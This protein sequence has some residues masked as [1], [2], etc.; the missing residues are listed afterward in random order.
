MPYSPQTVPALH[1][2]EDPYFHHAS[3]PCRS[4]QSVL[5]M[6][7]I[8]ARYD[9]ASIVI[10]SPMFLTMLLQV[11]CNS[12]QPCGNC[13]QA[14]LSCTYDAIPQKKGPKGSR[15]KVI[16]ELRETQKQTDLA[17]MIHEGRTSFG[18]PPTSPAYSRASGLLSQELIEGCTDFFFSHMYPTMPI[19]YREQ[20]RRTV[21]DMGHSA[22]AYCLITAFCA[23]MLIQPGIVLKTGHIMDEAAT[24]ITNPKMGNVLMEESARVRKSYD[25]IEN[26]TIDTIIT[27]FFLFGSC[28]GLNKHNTGW[29]HL[30]EATALA[31]ILGM[32]DE[33]TYIFDNVV[34]MSR[35]RRLFWLL[36]VTER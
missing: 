16:S 29:V 3:R 26:P 30:R 12:R 23:F 4:L 22:E 28:F 10:G 8:D 17:H 11:R 35:K 6:H 9:D 20:I 18:S 25:Y 1:P 36:F 24:S 13:N 19:L 5:V 15:A 27:S 33:N 21:S 14:G 7:V 31:Q 2:T 34:E 32:Q